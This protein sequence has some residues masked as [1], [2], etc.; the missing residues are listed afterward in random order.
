[1]INATEEKGRKRS[2]SGSHGSIQVN[3]RHGRASRQQPP[4]S[5]HF[6]RVRKLRCNRGQPCSNCLLRDIPCQNPSSRPLP[7]VS[8]VASPV[9]STLQGGSPV[10]EDNGPPDSDIV[11]RLE[12]LEKLASLQSE[13]W[14]HLAACHPELFRSIAPRGSDVPASMNACEI[15][16]LPVNVASPSSRAS[17][18]LSTEV[19]RLEQL[20]AGRT[21]PVSYQLHCASVCCESIIAHIDY[22]GDE[23]F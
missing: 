22:I 19:A 6:C 13:K 20:S 10:L 11:H 5:C 12:R 17:S 23:L 16:N 1:M 15:T 7:S 18:E 4:V 21:F 3:G 14:D 9:A 2:Q 8:V